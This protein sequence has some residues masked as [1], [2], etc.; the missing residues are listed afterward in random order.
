MTMRHHGGRAG[1]GQQ[2]STR[3]NS[4]TELS[5]GPASVGCAVRVGV[6]SIKNFALGTPR[7]EQG[8]STRLRMRCA[9]RDIRVP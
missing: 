4:E 2:S 6:T 9:S 3:E 5:C 1:G 7:S 8:G